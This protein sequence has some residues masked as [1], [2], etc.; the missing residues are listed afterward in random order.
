MLG[1]KTGTVHVRVR[2]SRRHG[3]AV[4]ERRI[5]VRGDGR[6]ACEILG[7]N[8]LY[9]ANEG[10]CLAMLAMVPA[11]QAETALGILPGHPVTPPSSDRCPASSHAVTACQAVVN[12][13]WRAIATSPRS[14]SPRAQPSVSDWPGLLRPAP[15]RPAKAARPSYP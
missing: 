9:V 11:E 13:A 6:G 3:M 14:C 8:P 2:S 5:A 7:L 15:S 10:R 4:D 1:A 12:A